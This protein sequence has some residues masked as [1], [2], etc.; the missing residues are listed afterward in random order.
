MNA[1]PSFNKIISADL[2]VT[3]TYKLHKMISS[4]QAEINTFNETHKNLAEKYG[5]ANDD[6]TV[7]INQLSEYNAELNELLSIEIE[8]KITQVGIPLSGNLKL[9]VSDMTALEPFIYFYTEE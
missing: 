8:T 4:L 9:S 2:P 3:I 1:V 6:G 7:T 5:T